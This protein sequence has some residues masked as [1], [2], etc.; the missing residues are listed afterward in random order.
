VEVAE[1]TAKAL[2]SQ[3]ARPAQPRSKP[4]HAH[5]LH[6]LAPQA[7]AAVQAIQA[8]R[9]KAPEPGVEPGTHHQLVCA[10]AA[11]PVL[12]SR[13][14]VLNKMAGGCQD[15]LMLL[16]AADGDEPGQESHLL[17]SQRA[18]ARTLSS[19][20][21]TTSEVAVRSGDVAGAVLRRRVNTP[22]RFFFCSS[23]FDHRHVTPAR[24]MR[25]A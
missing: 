7:P 24:D 6:E 1:Q 13:L 21:E 3:V 9:G 5:D 20:L 12:N 25:H 11:I 2:Q 8:V 15:L 17:Q 22:R 4:A 16:L 18:I 23:I 10:T 19:E 14:E